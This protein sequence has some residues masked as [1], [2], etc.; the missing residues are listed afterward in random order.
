MARPKFERFFPQVKRRAATFVNS[1][2][3]ERIRK[4]VKLFAGGD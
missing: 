4:R 1:M 3:T 2:G